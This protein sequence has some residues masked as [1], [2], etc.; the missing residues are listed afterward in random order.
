MDSSGSDS[1]PKIHQRFRRVEHG[2]RLLGGDVVR[3]E[4]VLELVQSGRDKVDR[5][6]IQAS[7]ADGLPGGDLSADARLLAKGANSSPNFRQF[8][9]NIGQT[10]TE[11]GHVEENRPEQ[12]KSSSFSSS[13]T[14]SSSYSYSYSNSFFAL[15]SIFSI[16]LLF[17]VALS[18]R[19][20]RVYIY[21]YMCVCITR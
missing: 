16:F 7:S 11:P 15:H 18:I 14:S 5:E 12:V 19:V 9:A 6:G 8:N 1:I 2:D 21:I 17:N 4:A 20:F 10:D 3:R 13:S